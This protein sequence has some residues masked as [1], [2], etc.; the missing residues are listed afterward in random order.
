MKHAVPK[1]TEI[2]ADKRP[3]RVFIDLAGPFHVESLAES[4]FAM[5]CVFSRYKIVTFMAKKSDATAVL[6]AIIARYFAPAGLNIGVIRT[7]NGGKFQGAFQSLLAE[8]GIRNERLLRGVTESASGRLSV[9]AMA[10]AC[11]MSNKCVT[12]SLDHDKTPYEMWHG[13]PLAFDTVDYR[14]MEKPAHKLALRGAKCII[15][16]TAGRHDVNDRHTRGTFRVRDLT[17]IW[18]QAITWQ[19]AAGAAGNTPLAAAIGWGVKGDK[20][21]SPQLEKHAARTGTLGA[22]LGLEE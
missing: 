8:L 11:D 12:D 17:T 7:V 22:E 5:L 21:H 1:S 16:G 4:R 18:R 10:Y 6:R 3:G 15:L 14:R 9:E 2:R 13:R 20:N 19:L